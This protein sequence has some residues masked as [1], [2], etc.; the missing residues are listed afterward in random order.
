PIW[1]RRPAPPPASPTRTPKRSLKP[2]ERPPRAVLWLGILSL[3]T[4]AASEMIYPLLPLFL[5]TV[6]GAGA[7]FVGL[8]EGA[9]EATAS[10]LKLYSGRLADRVARRKPLTIFG[11][12]ISS[13]LRPLAAFATAPWMILAVRVGDRVGKG[14]R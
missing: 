5:T 11:Y 8:V 1:L 6:L 10:L 4:D 9:A 2:T 14:I 3:A 13:T 12:A 7:G